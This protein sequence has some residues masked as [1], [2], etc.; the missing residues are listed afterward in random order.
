MNQSIGHALASAL[1]REDEYAGSLEWTELIGW[2]NRS[3][4]VERL[5]LVATE[6]ATRNVFRGELAEAC[7][8]GLHLIFQVPAQFTEFGQ[9]LGYAE[10]TVHTS[11]H[12]LLP[13]RLNDD[14]VEIITGHTGE[15]NFRIYPHGA[16]QC[17]RPNQR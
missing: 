9:N 4:S 1:V 2:V 17:P 16:I 14:S 8:K 13:M 3:A 6:R 7:D 15:F 12:A 5:I 10:Y 11:P